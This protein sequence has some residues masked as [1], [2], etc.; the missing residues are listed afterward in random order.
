[1]LDLGV[2][3]GPLQES[4]EPLNALGDETITY[5]SG[6]ESRIT[7]RTIPRIVGLESPDVPQREAKNGANRS[8]AESPKIDSESPSEL[9]PI[10]AQSE[11]GTTRFESHDSESLDSRFSATNLHTI[12][13]EKHYIIKYQRSFQRPC[14]FNAGMFASKIGNPCPTLG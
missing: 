9:H 14:N 13:R 7:N 4:Q 6:T 5:L 1:M 10:N 8:K 3:R 11:L 12:C 2:A